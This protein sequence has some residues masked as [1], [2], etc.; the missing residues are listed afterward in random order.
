MPDT[1]LPHSFPKFH[2]DRRTVVLLI[3]LTLVTLACLTSPA[4]VLQEI[5]PTP[6]PTTVVPSAT[7]TPELI[8]IWIDPDLPEP[9]QN[10]LHLPDGYTHTNED[11]SDIQFTIL[12]NEG[13]SEW[14]YALTTPFF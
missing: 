13:L 2:H 7:S 12:D 5:S 9:I 6:T 8:K 14:V 4:V 10:S 3:L 11:S 1:H